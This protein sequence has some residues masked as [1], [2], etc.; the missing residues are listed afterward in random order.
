MRKKMKTDYEIQ[1]S[2]V[3]LC[4]KY[5]RPGDIS[6]ENKPHGIHG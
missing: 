1:F 3:I 4:V 5:Y 6:S 2:L